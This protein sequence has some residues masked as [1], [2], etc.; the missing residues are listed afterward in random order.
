MNMILKVLL[1][2]VE[3]PLLEMGSEG[4]RSLLEA[5]YAVKPKRTA[6]FVSI[7]HSILTESGRDLVKKT[8]FKYDDDVIEAAIAEL[9]AFA[10][11]KGFTLASFPEDEEGGIEGGKTE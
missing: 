1:G 5:Q 9:E 6:M 2:A 7:G 3:G 4:F 11:E 10:A 8:N